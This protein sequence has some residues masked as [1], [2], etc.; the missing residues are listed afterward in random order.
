MRRILAIGIAILAVLTL[1][2]SVTA[3]RPQPRV[4]IVVGPVEN[5]TDL[6]RSIGAAAAREARRWTNDVVVVASPDAT[7]PAVKR[8]LRGASIVVYL[9]HGNGFPSPYRDALYPPTQNGLGLNPVGGAGDESH[10]YFGEA[11]IGRDIRL[12]PGAVVL[13]HHLCY[14]SGNSEPGV[15]EGPLEVGRQRVDNYAAGWLR[16]GASAVIADTF[17][18][19]GPYLRAILTTDRPIGQVWRDAPTF[20]DHV[21]TFPSVRTPGAFGAMD[22]T[23]VTSG[24]NRSI[25][26]R[27]GLRSSDVLAGAGRVATVPMPL[28]GPTELG[29]GSLAGLGVTFRAP[30]LA[31][32]ARAPSGLVA[33]T[34]ASLSL[35][36]KAPAGVRLPQNLELGVRWDPMVVDQGP[37]AIDDARSGTT[38]APGPSTSP[39]PTEPAPS[40]MP[41]THP[42]PPGRPM[43]IASPED[44]T[45]SAVA[46][47]PA[48]ELVAPEVPGTIVTP[49]RAKLSQGRLKLTVGLP[50]S[51]GTYRLTTTVHGSDGVAYDAATQALVPVLTVKVSRPLSVAFGVVSD[52]TTTAGARLTI[53]VR[54]A[55]NGLLAWALAPVVNEELIDPSVARARPP[56]RLVAHW[57]P[58]AVGTT[59]DASDATTPVRVDPGG[60]ATVQLALTAPTT[61]GDYL[62]ILDISSPLH[63]SL[64]ASGVAVGQIRVNVAPAVSPAA[65]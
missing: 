26:M 9:G 48:I 36:I 34:K 40:A 45:N 16:A 2:G 10:Q 19:P 24:F 21:L 17:G 56:S 51:P 39:A 37:A 6:Y 65:P 22:P 29:P 43:P 23:H 52:L 55:N 33:G 4:A 41:S 5:L 27:A 28:V 20:H 1:P 15:P 12:A 47:P 32:A 54:L 58:L 11:F 18:E 57:V 50:A 42:R 7:W 13:L 63:G 46:P 35:P 38:S 53:P 30:S 60:E 44:P 61:P 64:A 3:A 25:V 62:V 14:A 8:A 31:S 49:A 59:S